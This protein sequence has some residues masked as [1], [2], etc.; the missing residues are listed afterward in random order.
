MN[1]VAVVTTA[2]TGTIDATGALVSTVADVWP[3]AD[4]KVARFWSRRFRPRSL[5]CDRHRRLGDTSFVISRILDEADQL[6]L[7]LPKYLAQLLGDYE[8]CVFIGPELL[9]VRP[10]IELVRAA[11][12]VGT[13]LVVPGTVTPVYSLT[14]LLGP[15]E[16]GPFLP[17]TRV[18]AVTRAGRPFLNHWAK[19]LDE[20]VL[21]ADQ[22][23][24]DWAATI[25]L[26]RSIARSDVAVE[27][28]DTLLHWAEYAAVEV[29]RMTGPSAA[30]VACDALFTSARELDLS[31]DPEVA[32]SMLV[33]RVH[34]SRPV[35]P[36]LEMIEASQSLA[37]GVFPRRLCSTSCDAAVWRAAD[38]Y[39]RR[40]GAGA[41]DDFDAWLFAHQRCWMHTNRGSAGEG[42]S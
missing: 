34:D 29:G 37:G 28:E 26:Q 7:C 6:A 24:I 31:D 8:T 20:A 38:P 9:I 33:H 42:R 21:D 4:V 3:E 19:T 12:T 17:D 39:G 32:W 5:G 27:G 2:Q 30:I 10:P 22:R 35:E 13:A 40:W 16:A 41:T 25:F 11:S 18:V 36:L 14:P 15:I 1:R 23:S